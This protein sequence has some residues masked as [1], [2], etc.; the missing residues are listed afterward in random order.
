MH[1]TA[2]SADVVDSTGCGDAFHG[3]YIAAVLDER[4]TAEAIRFAAAA[5]AVSTRAIGAQAGLPRREE[6]EACL[7][8]Q[9]SASV[10]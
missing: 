2:F 5:A 8:A 4:S 1:Q 3:A 7:A 6:V 10:M 9:P